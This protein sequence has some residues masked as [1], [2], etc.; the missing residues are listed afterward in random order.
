MPLV[1]SDAPHL[2]AMTMLDTST[3]WR[4]RPDASMTMRRAMSVPAWMALDTPPSSW[5]WMISTCL[6]VAAISWTIRSWSVPS[7][8]RLTTSTLARLGLLPRLI[9]VSVT[10]S[11][12]G[13]IWQQPW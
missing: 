1:V 9:R 7:Q 3:G 13:G 6:P 5:M 11:R 4:C 10:R 2:M 12:S 8:P